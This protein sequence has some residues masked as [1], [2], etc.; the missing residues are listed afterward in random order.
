[1]DNHEGFNQYAVYDVTG[2]LL[3]QAGIPQAG[4]INLHNLN[5]G[6]YVLSLFNQNLRKTFTVIISEN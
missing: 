1:L 5:S 6:F 4:N 2:R 3:L